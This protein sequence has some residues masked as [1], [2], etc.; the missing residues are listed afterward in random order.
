MTRDYLMSSSCE[1]M[2][3]TTDS[4]WCLIGN[5]QAEN[6]FG[7]ERQIRSGTH[8]FSPGSKVYCLPSQWGDGLESINVIAR[9]RGS[10]RF[11][12]MV[13][14][15]RWITNWRSKVVYNPEVLRLLAEHCPE[16]ESP[17]W[18]SKDQVDE[19]VTMFNEMQTP[20]APPRQESPEWLIWP[21]GAKDH[22]ADEP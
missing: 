3:D 7:P 17:V 6:V 9:H 13:A 21:D 14:R 10:R 1:M 2:P 5:I 22:K 18:K 20:P 19:Y 15:T 16:S 4:Q 8:H 12:K 11:V